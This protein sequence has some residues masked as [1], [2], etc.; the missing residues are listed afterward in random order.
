ML[1]KLFFISTLLSS[2]IP[3]HSLDHQKS[4]L[5]QLKNEL[6]FDSSLSTK[7]VQWNQTEDDDQCCKWFG[8]GCDDDGQIISLQLDNESISGGIGDLSSLFRLK[9]LQKLNLAYNDFNYIS[10]PRGIHNLTYLTHLN[11]SNAGFAGQVPFEISSLRRLVRLDFSSDYW[12]F[13]PLKLK[14]PNLKMLLRNMTGLRELY[15]DGVFISS[16]ER[17]KW[18]HIISSYLP[19]L[20]KL[21]LAYC[22]LSGPLAKSFSQ[23]HFLSVLRLDLNNLSTTGLDL[24]ANFS[25]LTTLRLANCNLSGSFPSMIIQIPTLQILDLSQNELLSGSIPPFPQNGFLKYI[26]L[27]HT[28][29]SGSI[30]SSISNLKAVSEIKLSHCQFT[31]SILSTFTHLTQ[32]IYVDLLNNFFIS[33]LSSTL[34]EGLS[35]L[36][37]LYLGHN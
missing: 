25:S 6:V 19:H 4:L 20:T 14:H 9:Y 7:L 33:S 3:S 13:E 10:I 28:K 30:P 5:L 23:L 26:A 16:R 11:L 1:L 21:S 22:S 17:T 31:G 8:V 35:N 36:V 29:F 24:L 27:S 12:D 2:L 32:L 18:S 15:L 34:F 37:H